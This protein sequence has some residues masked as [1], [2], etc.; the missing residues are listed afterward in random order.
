MEFVG[1]DQNRMLLPEG[2]QTDEDRRMVELSKK[3]YA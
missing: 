3:L 1:Y 2:E